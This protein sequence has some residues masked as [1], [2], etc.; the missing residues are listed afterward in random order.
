MNCNLEE[1]VCA[2]LAFMFLAHRQEKE[3]LGRPDQDVSP[4]HLLEEG[5][6]KLS[7]W[8]PYGR[9]SLKCGEKLN[10]EKR[11]KS[12]YAT[13]QVLEIVKK[14]DVFLKNDKLKR[15]SDAQYARGLSE[16]DEI[17]ME[18]LN[19]GEAINIIANF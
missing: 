6:R 8:R 5:T 1:G 13:K 11:I 18:D 4:N 10:F 2:G 19:E 7:S 3:A 15:V 14:Q 9:R 16:F 12:A 17:T